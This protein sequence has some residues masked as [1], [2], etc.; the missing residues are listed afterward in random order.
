MSPFFCPPYWINLI[1]TGDEQEWQKST[2]GAA[3]GSER[4]PTASYLPHPLIPLMLM[5]INT[6][7][8]ALRTQQVR[9]ADGFPD[10]RISKSG[11]LT[12]SLT[13]ESASPGSR[14]LPR[15]AN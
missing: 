7:S 13:C 8:A 3:K 10:M 5:R 1:H 14:R 6:A 9:E 11:K 2:S 12:V 4:R 15:H